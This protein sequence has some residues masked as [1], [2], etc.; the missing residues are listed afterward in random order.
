MPLYH[1]VK[2][3]FWDF[4]SINF[5]INENISKVILQKTGRLGM[6]LRWRTM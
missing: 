4:K 2:L 3:K 6:H 1:S 5:Y